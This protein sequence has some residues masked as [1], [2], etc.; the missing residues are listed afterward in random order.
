MLNNEFY[1]TEQDEQNEAISEREKSK[2]K[3]NLNNFKDLRKSGDKSENEDEEA[4]N[5]NA[6]QKKSQKRLF[7]DTG[8]RVV[9]E[10]IYVHSKV[11]IIDDRVCII[12]SANINDRSKLIV[13][14]YVTVI[15]Y[16]G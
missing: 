14:Y 6:M 4:E 1:I 2:G 5:R 8:K 16:V 12:G 7:T 9:T 11:M 15:R 13:Q 3:T 10:Q